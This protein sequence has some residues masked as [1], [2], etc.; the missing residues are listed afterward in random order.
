MLITTQTA[1]TSFSS[2][3]EAGLFY[4]LR[5]Y[6]NQAGVLNSANYPL[7]H[8]YCKLQFE[9]IELFKNNGK[10]YIVD[11]YAKTIGELE[12]QLCLTPAAMLKF[13]KDK[14]LMQAKQS[15][16]QSDK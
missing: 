9:L 6:L 13:Q 7:L 10:P 1:F 12:K 3:P 2:G 4:S 14:V 8:R 5:D 15:K 16:L 11:K